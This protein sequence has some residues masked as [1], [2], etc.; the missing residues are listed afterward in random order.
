MSD[1]RKP[2]EKPAIVNSRKKKSSPYVKQV[3]Y[4]FNCDDSWVILDWG[5]D[6]VSIEEAGKGSYMH[7]NATLVNGR[8]VL[9]EDSRRH[10]AM[11]GCAG[12]AD[13]I[14]AHFN[15]HGMP[16]RDET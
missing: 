13:A 15:K 11:Y 6:W 5:D 9:D 4:A 1:T 10:I 2:Y 7:A 8:W 16:E 14:E 12:E 3:T